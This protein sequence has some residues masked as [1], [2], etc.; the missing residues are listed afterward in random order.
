MNKKAVGVL[1]SHVVV[2]VDQGIGAFDL[3]DMVDSVF[4]LA[5]VLN[6][7][8]LSEPRTLKYWYGTDRLVES[9]SEA[10]GKGAHAL[11]YGALVH[12]R[13]RHMC[14]THHEE[15]DTEEV[16]ALG[17][18]E[19]VY[20]GLSR[21]GQYGCAMHVGADTDFVDEGIVVSEPAGQAGSLGAVHTELSSRLQSNAEA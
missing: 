5:E 1:V 14:T 13:Q 7:Q 9:A 2:R 3:R 17:V 6:G 12:G 16:D 15:S 21:L 18:H 19:D 11:L 10:I 8:I 4:V 20:G